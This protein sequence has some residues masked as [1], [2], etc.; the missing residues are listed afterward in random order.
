MESDDGIKAFLNMWEMNDLLFML[1]LENLRDQEQ[2]EPSTRPWFVFTSGEW[3][4]WVVTRYALAKQSLLGEGDLGTLQEPLT[5]YQLKRTSFSLARLITGGV[6][7]LFACVLAWFAAGRD[8]ADSWCR[9]AM[10]TLAWFWFTCPTQNP[11]YWCWVM[12][13]LPFAKYRAWHAVAAVTMLYYLA[14]LAYD[15]TLPC[16]ERSWVRLTTVRIFSTSSLLG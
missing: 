6:F 1:V 7:M 13:L 9:A 15:S 2:E 11:W 14:V 3:S 4:R 16:R 8:G 12:P 10:L 5:P